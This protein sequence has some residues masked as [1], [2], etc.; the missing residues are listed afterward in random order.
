MKDD[1]Y[2]LKK[3]RIVEV[4]YS[5]IVWSLKALITR[6]NCEE[7]IFQ[8]LRKSVSNYLN[9]VV[10]TYNR[11]YKFIM[12]RVVI[13]ISRGISNLSKASVKV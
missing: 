2:R 9:L 13:A 3:Y 12:Y 7:L 10:A 8:L 11:G 4:S 5:F 6:R 1:S